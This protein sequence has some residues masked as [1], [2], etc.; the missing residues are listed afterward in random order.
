VT[1]NVPLDANVGVSV[2]PPK[3]IV[4]A[5][6]NPVPVTVSVNAADPAAIDIGEIVVMTTVVEMAPP[7]YAPILGGVG[8][9]MPR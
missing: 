6:V 9:A 1:V 8:R 4:D 7:S 5:A 3:L 2:V